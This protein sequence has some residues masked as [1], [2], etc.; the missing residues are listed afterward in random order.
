MA[1]VLIIDAEG[2]FRD[3]LVDTLRSLAHDVEAAASGVLGL[4]AMHRAR[5]DAVFLVHRV[6][7]MDGLQALAALGERAADAPRLPPLVVLTPRAGS[8]NTIA[9]MRLGAFDHLAEPIGR[10]PL[11]EV[12]DRALLHA[13][14]GADD[15][16]PADRAV[17]GDA[18]QALPAGWLAAELPAATQR[19]EREM[20]VHALARSN[21]NRAEAS[22]RLGIHR[23]LLY[24][25]L[26]QYGIA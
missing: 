26:A 14:T 9:A 12:L 5:F 19:L 24:R 11:R 25:K 16:V 1:R 8:N 4:L 13:A 20:I 18:A 22:R 21:G 2:G 3:K 17:T 6:P 10:E 23:Q 7:G 15:S